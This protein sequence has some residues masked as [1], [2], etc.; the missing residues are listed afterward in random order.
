MGCGGA[1]GGGEEL[2][3]VEGPAG[4]R[5]GGDLVRVRELNLCVSGPSEGAPWGIGW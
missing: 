1:M 2:S 4:V 5:N 3:L